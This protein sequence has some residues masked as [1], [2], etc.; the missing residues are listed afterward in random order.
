MRETNAG[1]SLRAL[2]QGPEWQA[3]CTST[4]PDQSRAPLS[5]PL[6]YSDLQSACGGSSHVQAAPLDQRSLDR[7][8]P[9]VPTDF[10][11][12]QPL[13]R[14]P[15]ACGNTQEERSPE[16]AGDSSITN[17]RSVADS[18]HSEDDEEERLRRLRQIFE[19]VDLDHD[20]SLNK[21]ELI[22]TLR[23]SPRMA[24]FFGLPNCIRQED[25]T[26]NLVEAWFQKLDCDSN[27]EISWTEFCHFYGKGRRLAERLFS[28]RAIHN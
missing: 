17:A 5:L 22:K 7:S 25:G 26:R 1:P 15:V 12:S 20:G 18:R 13:S 6:T 16:M 27:R 10:M 19:R 11:T 28:P 2:G 9:W 3:D 14:F 4:A 8:A 21:R 24:E 23:Q